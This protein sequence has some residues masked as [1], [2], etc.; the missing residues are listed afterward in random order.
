[1]WKSQ[2]DLKVLA[3]KPELG[4]P[5]D[6]GKAR[7]TSTASQEPQPVHLVHASAAG[8]ESLKIAPVRGAVWA[9]HARETV[10]ARKTLSD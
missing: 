7:N 6:G 3:S 5:E 8:F 1:M 9:R 2:S 4:G 10:D